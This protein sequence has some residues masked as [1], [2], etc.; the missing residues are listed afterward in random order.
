MSAVRKPVGAREDAPAELDP[1]ELITAPRV[2]RSELLKVGIGLAVVGAGMG[3]AACGSDSDGG[4]A[5]AAAGAPGKPQALDTPPT[6]LF[7][8]SVPVG[9]K[10][11]L[12]RRIAISLPAPGELFTDFSNAMKAGS[13]VYD[14][15]YLSGQANGDSAAQF[16]QTEQFLQRGVGA[17]G[18]I[19]LA[20]PALVPLQLRAIQRGIPVFSGAYTNTTCQIAL[21][22]QE[23]GRQMGEAAMRFITAE[24]G[25]E[26][27]VVI[28]NQD[29][30]PSFRPRT[31]GI[32]EVLG[33]GG[34]G[35]EVVANVDSPLDERT[36]FDTARTILQKNPDA[37]VW[38]GKD[39]GLAGIVAAYRSAG[40]PVDGV[41]LVGTDGDTAALDAIAAGG[42]YKSTIGTA[43]PILAY[44]WTVYANDWLDG[45]SIPLVLDATGIVLDSPQA[46]EDFRAANAAPAES[47]RANRSSNAYFTPRGNTSYSDNKYLTVVA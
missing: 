6:A 21:S 20:P 36:S 3:V 39:S 42:P 40:K 35:V 27:K 32:L 43:Y 34:P 4:G 28:F 19:D 22:W 45:K 13:D 9:P 29:S 1:I 14:L 16:R 7:D 38:I 23:I 44:A 2:T 17:L 12:P 25:G 26:A 11:D 47:L 10:P 15:E 31:R 30:N 46:I 5:G 18:I 24:L 41:G 37:N 33:A 8:P